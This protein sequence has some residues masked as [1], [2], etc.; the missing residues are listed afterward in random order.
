MSEEPATLRMLWK[1]G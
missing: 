1:L